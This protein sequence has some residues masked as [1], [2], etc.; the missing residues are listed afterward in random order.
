MKQLINDDHP[1][2]T[3]G[4]LLD[5]SDQII[6]PWY[7]I[8]SDKS[9]CKFWDLLITFLILYELIVVPFVLVFPEKY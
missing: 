5:E 8:D 2:N 9:F 7:L 1:E 3:E 4:H 6:S